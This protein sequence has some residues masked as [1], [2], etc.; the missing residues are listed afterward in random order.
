MPAKAK[1]A[2]GSFLAECMRKTSF[3]KLKTWLSSLQQGERGSSNGRPVGKQGKR[4][5]NRQMNNRGSRG[6]GRAA[7]PAPRAGHAKKRGKG[8]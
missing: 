7:R 2:F 8:R 5:A 1:D 4:P 3:R 6:P